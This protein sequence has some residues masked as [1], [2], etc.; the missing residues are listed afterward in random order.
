MKFTTILAGVFVLSVLAMLGA[1]GWVSA[2]AW[3]L[4]QAERTARQQTA[5]EEKARLALW[6]MD[7]LLTPLVAGESAR[8]YFVYFNSLPADSGTAGKTASRAPLEM[9]ISSPLRDETS[10]YVLLHFQFDPQGRLTSPQVPENGDRK[11]AGA[12][13]NTAEPGARFRR[14]FEEISRF[15]KR[16]SLAARLPAPPPP[17]VAIIE[18]PTQVA[19]TQQA[20]NQG[21]PMPGD[22]MNRGQTSQNDSLLQDRQRNVDFAQ[23]A[24]A[25]EAN[26][27]A[28]MQNQAVNRALIQE[29]LPNRRSL[30]TRQTMNLNGAVMTPLWIGGHCVLARRVLVGGREYLQGCLLDWPAIRTWLKGAIA[31]L[32]PEA[33]LEP[34]A[35]SP[36]DEESP[37]LS[38]LPVRLRPGT[39][40]IPASAGRS[41][42]LF[43]LAAAW[44][45][46]LVAIAAVAAALGGVIRLSGR[47]A[48]FVSAVT[49]ELR[50]PLTT[51]QMYAE[52][53]ADGMVQNPE[54][55]RQYLNTLRAEALRLTHLVENVLAYARLER[56]RLD[57]RRETLPLGELAAV[58]EGRLRARAEQAGMELVVEDP[59]GAGSALVRAN[60]SAVEQILFNLVDNACKYAA[61]AED[62]R[63]VLTLGHTPRQAFLRVADY[64]PGLTPSSRRRL[65]RPF[66]KSAREAAH[67]APGV[68]LG[69]ALSRRLARDLDGDL[70][71]ESSAPS[72]A[73]FRLLLPRAS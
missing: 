28:V 31:D 39:V 73:H 18:V 65:F 24:G 40:A 45:C 61:G 17:A 63:I 66:S 21:P 30:F 46:L 7:S 33:Q 25:V 8:P 47:R 16:D 5:T 55:Q 10:P 19:R 51:F 69:L 34:A 71:Y 56:G 72:G 50:T 11:S 13:A 59:Q 62:K 15:L 52:M 36:G 54:Q 12:P 64:G 3:R 26:V 49:H 29:E 48:A 9:R 22:S 20:R 32:L 44:F 68:G 43:S 70:K 41:P 23:R 60:V 35:E 38:A 37:L 4:E 2:A 27:Q 14:L 57:R 42:V 53:L 6:R 67:S 58:L 1:M